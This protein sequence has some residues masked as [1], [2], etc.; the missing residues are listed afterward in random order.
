MAEVYQ[1]HDPKLKRKVALKVLHGDSKF[2][3]Q[4][5][6][7]FEA[8][9]AA[10]F[11]HP[12]SVIIYDVGEAGDD[13]FIAMELIRG[14]R[15]SEFVRDTTVPI[16]RKIRWLV[17]IARALA[18]AH[19][20]GLVHRDIK[21]A[22]VMIREEDNDAKVLDFGIARQVFPE[23]DLE[24]DI[25]EEG[26]MVGTIRYA[27][28][29]QITG[30]QVD[31]RA[32]QFSWGITAFQ[33]L[34]GRMPFTEQDTMAVASKVVLETVPSLGDAAPDLPSDVIAV[35][36]KAVSREPRDRFA[37]MDDVADALENFAD[38][39]PSLNRQSTLPNAPAVMAPIA[40]PPA[41]TPPT[42]GSQTP[43][44]TSAS[45]TDAP[46]RQ[47]IPAPEPSKPRRKWLLGAAGAVALAGILGIASLLQ[48]KPTEAPV[49]AT[50]K[51][52]VSALR[53]APA[54]VTGEADPAIA[55][56]LGVSACA[57]LGLAVGVPWG[58]VNESVPV[59]NT[60]VTFGSDIE[61][62]LE[63]Q[64]QRA[65]A[66]AGTP[67]QALSHSV[68]ALASTIAPP[69][70]TERD[71]KAWGAKDEAS[72][73]RIERVWRERSLWVGGDGSAE[74]K[75]LQETDP[76]SPF[77]HL[78]VLM[79]AMA[80]KESADSAKKSVDSLAA[81]LPP[82]REK[83]LRGLL[84][85]L[86]EETDRTEA[87]KLLRIAYQEAPGDADVAA[88]FAAFA[89]RWGLPEGYGAL[90]RL[91]STAPT[92]SLLAIES[93]LSR[94]PRRDLDRIDKY[95][96]RMV[97][98]FPEARAVPSVIRALVTRGKLEEARA[99]L[100]F[101]RKLGL[102]K[103]PAEPL[104]FAD[105]SLTV[106]LASGNA[107]EARRLALEILGDPAPLRQVVGGH[108]AASSLLLEGKTSQAEAVLW[109]SAERHRSTDDARAA[110][111]FAVR[112]LAVRRLLK[113]PPVGAIRLDW[114]RK[115]LDESAG[116]PLAQRAEGL[117]E[118][119]LTQ[120][121]LETFKVRTETLKKVEVIAEGV[122]EPMRRQ[123][124]LVK[125]IPLV[126]ALQG[127]KLAIER[128]RATAEAPFGARLRPAFDVA[129]ALDATG[130]REGALA[131]YELAADAWNLR[132][133][134]L[135]RMLAIHRISRLL[136]R[137]QRYP[138]GMARK[139]DF[140]AMWKGA[141]QGARTALELIR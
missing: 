13:T 94:A 16:G 138:E 124:I 34:S 35:I 84:R 55:R 83:A 66:R 99:A 120:T 101:A 27:A 64:G 134:M 58:D 19:R 88:I 36:D 96:S 103:A 68:T 125:T 100:A 57:R 60:T 91:L 111:S 81:R 90:D 70:L 62:I 102:D 107:A 61:V 3:S 18:A 56:A 139:K 12:N 82:A 7:F 79:S 37:S 32:D 71:V 78:L 136:M 98:I 95:A 17:S 87:A 31:G 89:V 73:R 22:N 132:E 2:Y 126:R 114:L 51:P 38:G 48:S 43:P 6:L 39:L 46:A 130:D 119:A 123:E 77:P 105:S 29:E 65:S 28:P 5:R 40:Q 74:A 42:P 59:V 20:K 1:A 117:V 44:L 116:L 24:G 69:S 113:Q 128:W 93:A 104:V 133:G 129:L 11:Q 63:V 15:L 54:A 110:V 75:A 80:G 4:K 47:A 140:D 9:A 122:P 86:P 45:P 118:V 52:E 25:T 76:E 72:A 97:E 14:R 135:E 85:A 106:E 112:A 41:A 21:P 10:N 137:M 121:G 108:G 26:Q 30:E 53:C 8:Q 141:E 92:R 131:T 67:I 115:M 33:L 50:G 23:G 109:E 127:D 49:Q